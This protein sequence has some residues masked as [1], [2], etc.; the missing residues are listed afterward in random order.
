MCRASPAPATARRTGARWADARLRPRARRRGALESWGARTDSL[1]FDT[2]IDCVL[3]CLYGYAHAIFPASASRDRRASRAERRMMR[4]D[5]PLTG[6]WAA[7]GILVALPNL[8][9]HRFGLLLARI[10]NPTVLFLLC[11]VCIVPVGLAMRAFGYDPLRLKRDESVDTYWAATNPR[12]SPNRCAI[13][14]DPIEIGHGFLQG[15]LALPQGPQGILK[16]YTPC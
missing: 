10:V 2:E 14:S 16:V 11:A 1:P 13:G 8:L 12:P 4:Y 6:L 3:R 9:Q 15:V 7:G 5:S